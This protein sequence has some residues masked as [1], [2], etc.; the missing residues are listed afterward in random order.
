MALAL[1]VSLPACKRAS[2][3]TLPALPPSMARG[4]GAMDALAKRDPSVAPSDPLC[5]GRPRCSITERLPAHGPEANRIAVVRLA[6]PP[7]AA[8]DE[9]RCNRREYWLTRPAADLLLAADCEE[10]WGADNAGPAEMTVSGAVAKFHYV[11]F[12]A[13]DGCEIVDAALQLPQ[14]RI[15]MHIRQWGKVVGNLCLPTRKSAPV[16]GA[17]P[18][19]IDHPILVLHRP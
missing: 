2:A 6:A 12:L 5:H 13:D 1:A 7:N 19:T 3:P 4:Q 18:G 17:G 9:D 11:E 16:P 15:E 10:Q 14:G 8:S